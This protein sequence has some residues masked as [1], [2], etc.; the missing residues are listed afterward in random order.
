MVVGIISLL[1]IISLVSYVFLQIW[2]DKELEREEKV[3][4][5]A[6][7]VLGV[8]GAAYIGLRSIGIIN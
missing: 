7:A 6:I 8:L 4:V 3:L 1:A 2:R 5:T